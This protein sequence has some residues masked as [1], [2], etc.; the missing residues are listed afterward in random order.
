MAA[1]PTARV[2]EGVLQGA[3][4]GGVA[5]FR[6]APFAAPPVGELRWRAPRPH[7]GWEGVRAATA[8]GAPAMQPPPTPSLPALDVRGQPSE[9]CLYLNVW[10]PEISQGA[11][12]PVMVWVHGGGFVFGSGSQPLYDGA[13]LARLGVMVVTIN[14]RLGPFGFL[15]LAEATGGQIPASGVEGLLDQ[16]AAL[17]WVRDNIA[18]FGGDPGRVT[19]FGESAGAFSIACLL[20]MPAAKGLF[21]RAILQSGAASTVASK[22][23]ARLAAARFLAGLPG[24]VA[25]SSGEDILNA[26]LGLLSAPSAPD[27]AL[28]VMPFQPV[29]DGE[30]LPVHPLDAIAAGASRDV[31][32][33]IGSNREEWLLF[34]DPAIDA[35]TPE[36]A[37][38]WG[39]RRYGARLAP[40]LSRPYR[41]RAV[42]ARDLISAMETDRL[43]T[44]PR[45]QFLRAR[46]GGGGRTLSY[47]FARPSPAWDG[48]LGACHTVEIGH[49]FGTAGHEDYAA[50]FGQGL[51]A[52]PR[53][54]TD[55]ARTGSPELAPGAA[56]PDATASGREIVFPPD[57]EAR[58][59]PI[60]WAA[61]QVWAAAGDLV[62]RA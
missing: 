18:A 54:W 61:E 8:F 36:D 6:G 44:V 38:A 20:A 26:G 60:D 48:A 29:V 1:D 24:E 15:R 11:G 42:T 55:F 25:A 9:D 17:G 39:E 12:L 45:L 32:V 59:G 21:Q 49:V 62:G 30:H 16:I 35:M 3:W 4:D 22:A 7:G 58:A 31:D 13:T 47:S 19:V 52:M 5:V 28:G 41:D 46:E 14:Y 34:A 56:W 57:G 51:A 27:P 10:T 50:F 23:Q 53:L 40:R 2:R 37:R 43:F 33:V